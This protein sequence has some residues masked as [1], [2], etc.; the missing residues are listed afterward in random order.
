MNEITREYIDELKKIIETKDKELAIAFLDDLHPADVA[1]LYND[2]SL[3][4]VIFLHLLMD[5]DKA[6]D[7]L[8]ELEEDE[9]GRAHV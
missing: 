1:E 2:L 4:E 3:K 7:V 6:G 8:M 9:I 5:G